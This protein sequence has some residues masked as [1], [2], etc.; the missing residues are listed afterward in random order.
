MPV[1]DYKAL[2]GNNKQRRGLIDAD[3][4]REAR[5]KLKREQL[6]VTDLQERK[7][8]KGGALQLKGI[9]GFETVNKQRSEQVAAVTRQMASLLQAGIPLS[10]GLRMVIEQS[11]TRRSRALSATSARR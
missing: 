5:V 1:F 4:A 10:D 3:T 9:T 8:R 7:K 11:P 6:Y 2:D